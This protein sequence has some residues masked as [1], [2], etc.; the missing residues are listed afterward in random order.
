MQSYEGFSSTP[1]AKTQLEY[2]PWSFNTV[3]SSESTTFLKRENNSKTEYNDR[4]QQ[5]TPMINLFVNLFNWLYDVCIIRI[6]S[7]ALKIH[8][9]FQIVF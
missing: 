6:T 2:K 4:T 5:A 8:G 1:Q 9:K 7:W 3:F